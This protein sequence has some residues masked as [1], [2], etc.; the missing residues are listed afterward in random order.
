[1]PKLPTRPRPTIES[2][3]VLWR[4]REVLAVVPIGASSLWRLVAEGEFPKPIRLTP[5]TVAWRATEVRE[6]I[7]QRAQEAGGDAA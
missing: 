5:R 4:Q 7:A 2:P 6:W 1:M 3:D